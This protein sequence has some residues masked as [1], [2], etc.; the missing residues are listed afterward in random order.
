MDTPSP[1]S[2]GRAAHLAWLAGQLAA[3][4]VQA[5]L[6]GPQ[7][8]EVLQ[9]VTSRSRKV[10]FVACVPAPQAR[11]WA[12]VWSRDWALVTDPRAVSMIVAAMSS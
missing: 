6:T 5:R 7:G 4:G 9:V 12:W 11:T 2:E 3:S 10:R 8:A 1:S